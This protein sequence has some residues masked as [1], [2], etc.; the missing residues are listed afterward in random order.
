[1]YELINVVIIRLSKNMDN[2]KEH[3]LHRLLGAMFLPELN[4]DEKNKVLEDEFK[5]P[6]EGKRKE[7][8]KSMCN[9][10]QGIKESALEQGFE[11][12]MV[13]AGYKIPA[14]V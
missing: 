2:E 8:L 12:K 13:S 1:M 3:E 10:S 14:E 4:I 5:T 7:L 9:L 6:M 11:K